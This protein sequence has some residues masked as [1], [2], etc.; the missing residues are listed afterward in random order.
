M[1]MFTSTQAIAAQAVAV[2]ALKVLLL[3][4]HHLLRHRRRRLHLLRRNISHDYKK[5][6]NTTLGARESD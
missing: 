6:R 1:E 3:L 4:F 5:Q 2:V